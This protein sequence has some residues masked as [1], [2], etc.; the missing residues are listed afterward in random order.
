MV[1]QMKVLFKQDVVEPL[2]VEIDLSQISLRTALKKTRQALDAAYAGFNNATEFDMIDSYIYEIN[3]LQHRYEHL[4]GLAKQE[5]EPSL[6]L[7]Q[8]SP[9]R[10]W[11]TR[12]FH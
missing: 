7:R 5:E 12:I 9:I 11:I 4:S 3:A 1:I 10:T 6:S 2:S 8:H